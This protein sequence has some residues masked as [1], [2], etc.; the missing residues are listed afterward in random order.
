MRL[1]ILLLL[2][3]IFWN[4]NMKANNDNYQIATFGAGCFWCVEAVFTE[5]RGVQS[6][7]PG[8]AGGTGSKPTYEA[9]CTGNTGYAEVAQIVYDPEIISYKELLE[10]F[11]KTHDPTTLN[12]QGADVGS[13]YRSVVFYHNQSQKQEA[14]FY[15][16]K[17][18]ESGAYNHPVVTEIVSLDAFYEAENYHNDYFENNPEQ[19]YCRFVIQPK[20]DKFRAAFAD[21]LK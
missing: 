14:E 18:D 8:Y 4:N 3:T 12:Q 7:T 19:A 6:V 10:V 20:V 13:Q 2:T 5:L 15:L 17:V 21:K 1:G 16:K 11:W 9:V